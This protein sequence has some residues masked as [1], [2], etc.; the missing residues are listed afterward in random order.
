[1]RVLQINANYGFGSTGVIMK[2]IGDMLISSDDEAYFAYQRCNSIPNNGYII[3]NEVDWKVHAL[4]SRAL[5]GQGYYSTAA[6]K[7]LIRYIRHIKPD[8]VHLHNLHSNY[9][10]IDLLFKFFA[11]DDIP[12]VITMHDC[13]YFTGKCFHYVD[14]NCDGF[15]NGCGNCKKK[16]APPASL[17]F[18]RSAWSLQ[19]KKKRLLSIP[20]IHFVGCSKWICQEAKKGIL[21][22][23]RISV[24]YNGVDTNIFSPQESN[25]KER[26]NIGDKFLVMGMANKWMQPKNMEIIPKLKKLADVKVM[27]VGCT[28]SQIEM[29]GQ[30][31]DTVIPVGFIRDRVELAQ[32]Y[33]AADVFVNL[34]HAD[35]L[36]T[37]N[38][39]SI[40]CGTP[41]ITYDSC[42]SPELVDVDTGIIVPENDQDG[43]IHAIDLARRKDWN[44]CS[45]VGKSKYDK[46]KCYKIY[47]RI[48]S[49]LMR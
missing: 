1:M 31:G 40:C 43:I 35:T 8:V 30:F 20:R 11:E 39:E 29:L 2:D 7:K 14:V 9:V 41:V 27:V 48:Y 15:L 10:N 19:N 21:S 12:V 4:L 37:V 44:M 6:T 42:G 25:L 32:H 3:G 38:M 33:S 24:V 17:I 49:D 36:P 16:T 5:G 13:W 45:E 28:D 26:Y 23:S 18:D 22:E 34:T 46:N 47:R